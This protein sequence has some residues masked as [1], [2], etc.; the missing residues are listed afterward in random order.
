MNNDALSTSSTLPHPDGSDTLQT[1]AAP[2]AS[3]DNNRVKL[4]IPPI[5]R[6]RWLTMPRSLADTALS[7]EVLR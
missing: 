2:L 7:G 5:S 1:P 4:P 3:N 6:R